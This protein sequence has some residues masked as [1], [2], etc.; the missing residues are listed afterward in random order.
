MSAV[1]A[2]QLRGAETQFAGVRDRHRGIW[3]FQSHRSSLS[4]R[5]D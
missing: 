3:A 4:S 5:F 1:A 2:Y